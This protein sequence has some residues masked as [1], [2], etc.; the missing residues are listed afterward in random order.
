MHDNEDGMI[1]LQSLC[2]RHQAVFVVYHEL[3]RGI[4]QMHDDEDEILVLRSMCLR[5]Q[6]FFLYTTNFFVVYHDTS[7]CWRSFWWYKYTTTRMVILRSSCLW[8]QD[9]F[10]VFIDHEFTTITAVLFWMP[11]FSWL[12]STMTTMRVIIIHRCRFVM[13]FQQPTSVWRPSLAVR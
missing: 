10:V 4:Q 8:H 3:L 2:L 13:I 9:F 6:A 1:I 11:S 7:F 12:K 5:H